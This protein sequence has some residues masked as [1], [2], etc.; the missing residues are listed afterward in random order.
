MVQA[1]F[2]EAFRLDR[3]TGKLIWRKPPPEHT[4]KIGAEAGY[5]CTGKGKNKSYWQVRLGGKTYKRARVVYLI[6]HGQWPSPCVDHI[7]GDSLDDRPENLRAATYRQNAQ[8]QMPRQ[9]K[10]SGLPQGVSPYK[11]KF[12]AQIQIDGKRRVI[13]QFDNPE[14]ASAA[15][16]TARKEAFGEYA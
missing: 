3:S 2:L 16:Q 9:N 7:N 1:D 6:E 13:G 4:E 15:Y 5:T 14:N 10:A 11:G 12:R 8:N